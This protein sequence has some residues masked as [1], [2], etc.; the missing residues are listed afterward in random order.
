MTMFYVKL[1]ARNYCRLIDQTKV[2][3][4]LNRS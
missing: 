4:I 1:G 3:I 2:V